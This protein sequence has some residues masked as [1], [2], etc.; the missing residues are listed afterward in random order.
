MSSVRGLGGSSSTIGW[1]NRWRTGGSVE[2]V[3]AE[4]RLSPEHILQGIE[5][6]VRERDSRMKQLR[7][8][9][10]LAEQRC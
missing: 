6:F 7:E 1:A 3:I 5:R 8:A 2:E 9:V 10:E 4:A